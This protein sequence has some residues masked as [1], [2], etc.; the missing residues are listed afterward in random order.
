MFL[1]QIII[2]NL[3]FAT[4]VIF[5]SN[6]L[7]SILSLIFLIIGSIFILFSLKIEFL[8][9]ILLLIYIGALVILFLFII[10]MLDIAKEEES[11]KVTSFNLS[12]NLIFY[13]LLAVKFLYYS[14]FFNKNLVVGI[15]MISF[16][17]TK[18]SQDTINYTSSSFYTGSDTIIFLSLFMTKN[19]LFVFVGLILLFSMFGSIA[20]CVKTKI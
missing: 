20:L 15:S 14:F 11:I 18:Y 4:M 1:N 9:F 6:S 12:M 2:G 13:F 5:S 7:Y 10:M 19:Y 8:S 17:F 3:F 16:E